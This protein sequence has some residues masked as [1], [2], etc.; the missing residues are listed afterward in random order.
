MELKTFVK[1]AL[2]D[3]IEAVQDAQTETPAGAIVPEGINRSFKS[4]EHGVSEL[5][6]VDFEVSVTAGE[7]KGSEGKLGVVTAIV[8]A[9]V[10]GKSSTESSNCSRL[11]FRIPVQL[12][13]S[14]KTR[15]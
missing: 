8:G 6:A 9:G 2:L 7:A 11:K 4:V 15:S 12:P 13:T 14:G 1:T 5:Q 3:I 10:A